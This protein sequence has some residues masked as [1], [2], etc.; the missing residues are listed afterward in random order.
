MDDA[1]LFENALC[2]LLVCDAE[3]GR[4]LRANATFRELAGY[5][6][7]GM[8]RFRQLLTRPSLFVYNAQLLPQLSLNG[9]AKEIALDLSGPGDTSIPVLVNA[10]TVAQPGQPATT[11]YAVFPARD[12]R[13]FER[14]QLKARRELTQYRDYLQLAE[15]LAHVGHWRSSLVDG[16]AY[17]SAEIYNI[18]GRDPKTYVPKRGSAIDQYVD[19]DRAAVEKIIETAIRHKSGFDFRK[20]IRRHNDGEIRII[21]C[22]GICETGEAGQVTGMFGVLHDMTEIVQTQGKLERSE[23]R[24]R[25]L[26]DQANDIITVF[27]LEGRFDYVSPAAQ[28]VLGYKPEDLIGR[29]VRA[30]VIP[31]DFE[32]T[33]AAYSAYVR[34]GDLRQSPR[35]QYRAHHKDGHVI[36]LEAHP[37]AI[38]GAEGRISRF[39]DVVRD[40]SE[41]KSTEAALA[42]ASLDANAAAE[43]KAN[44]L[45]TMSHELRTPLTSIIG[46]SALLRDLLSGQNDLKGHAARIHTAGQGLLSL[47]NDILDHSRLDA[48]QLEI[49][50]EPCDAVLVAEDVIDLP[51]VQAEAKGLDLHLTGTEPI[52]PVVMID[53]ARVRQ[54]LLNLAGNAIKFTASGCVTVALAMQGDRLHVSVRDTGIGIAPEA[55]RHLFQR[56]SQIDPDRG[57][58]GLGLLICKQLVERMGG[59]IGLR[60]RVG[61]GSEFWFEIPAAVNEPGAA[62]PK[63]RAVGHILVV[64]DQAAVRELLVN[65]L[66]AAGHDVATAADGRAALD[67]CAAQPYDLIFMDL[68]MPGMDG[69]SAAQ[70]LRASRGPNAA[71]PVLGLTA[72]GS[73]DRRRAC[74]NAGMNDMLTKPVGPS[75]LALAVARWMHETPRGQRRAG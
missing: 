61:E 26:A 4:I 67:A 13:E 56:F 27:D 5:Q 18:L 59:E 14:E 31:E 68:N 6:P 46:F 20:R 74:L 41:Q 16:T 30:I 36:W 12:R 32:R 65:L 73:E 48:G 21:Q 2:G 69:L 24:Y 25:L 63:A 50:P 51:C 39:Q 19:D 7:G 58:T 11:S 23:A 60:S 28:K 53:E 22:S 37:T 57:G 17:W 43:A 3:T 1:D 62:L 52:P 75:S 72:A 70:A 9:E 29:N 38:V 45:A 34:G 47:I 10:R 15:R 35:I 33:Q 42:R 66:N 64:D 54:I 8:T 49:E 71:T 44:F 40:I 55:Q